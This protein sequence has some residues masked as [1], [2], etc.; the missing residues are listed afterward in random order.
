MLGYTELGM[1]TSFRRQLRLFN[2]AAV[3]LP[4]KGNVHDV[5]LCLL[6]I[7]GK[8]VN[9][10]KKSKGSIHSFRMTKQKPILFFL[11]KI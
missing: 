9:D 10:G 8:S 5:W 11:L 4:T 1:K 7:K 3:I 6:S 2:K